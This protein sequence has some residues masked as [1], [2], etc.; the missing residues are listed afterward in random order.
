MVLRQVLRAALR[1]W[2][3][4]RT[5]TKRS[6]SATSQSGSLRKGLLLSCSTAG[7]RIFGCPPSCVRPADA[8]AKQRTTKRRRKRRTTT[9]TRAC[10]RSRTGPDSPRARCSTTTWALRAWS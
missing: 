10:S 6:G 4:R 3:R 9:P 7:A 2:S 8:L 5:T 1:H